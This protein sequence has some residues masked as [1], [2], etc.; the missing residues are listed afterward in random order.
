MGFKFWKLAKVTGSPATKKNADPFM[1]YNDLTAAIAEKEAK[2]DIKKD[3]K[4]EKK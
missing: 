3:I 1:P 2:K 4:K